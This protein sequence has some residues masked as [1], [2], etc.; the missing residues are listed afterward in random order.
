MATELT[1][2]PAADLPVGGARR[3]EMETGMDS[4]LLGRRTHATLADAG[5]V[6]RALACLA[7]AGLTGLL[8]QV[9]IPLP[10]TPVPLTGQVFAVLLAGVLL[11]GQLGAVS[12]MLYVVLGAAGLPWFAG[13]ASA[14]LL[15]ATSGYLLGFVPAAALVGLLAQRRANPGRV[16]L[17]LAMLAGVAVIYACGAAWFALF[18]G[19]GLRTTLTCTVL[20]F[21]PLD[22][23][24]AIAAACVASLLLRGRRDAKAGEAV[25]GEPGDR[26]R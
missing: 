19:F 1:C 10:W 18:T 24:K 15:G 21:V 22:I 4:Q 11:G 14:S 3:P 23:A 17:T 7:M 25:E 26:E 5:F 20:P 2:L 8:A 9:R 13:W 12:Q 6:S 16:R